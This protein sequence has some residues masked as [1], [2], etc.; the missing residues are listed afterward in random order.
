MLGALTGSDVELR[1]ARRSELARCDLLEERLT[2]VRAGEHRSGAPAES[3]T[4]I[5][6][7]PS[8][9]MRFL[10]RFFRS[11]AKG[12]GTPSSPSQTFANLA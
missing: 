6:S 10:I 7:A 4:I 8:D 1:A 2:R 5:G 11:Q 12:S 9:S 3:C